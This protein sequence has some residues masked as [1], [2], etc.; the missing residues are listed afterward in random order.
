M[1]ERKRWR[2]PTAKPGELKAQYGRVDGSLDIA[3][4]WGGGGAQSPDGRILSNALE[5]AHIH[6][7]K[8]LCEELIARGY[9]ITTLRFSIQQKARGIPAGEGIDAD[10]NCMVCGGDC[11]SANP[12]V[13][14]CPLRA[15]TP[16]ETNP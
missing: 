14:F 10:G 8:T 13:I 12:P 15:P 9:D 16:S 6:G 11:S 7:G 4:C 2:T 3:Y 1:S 5:G